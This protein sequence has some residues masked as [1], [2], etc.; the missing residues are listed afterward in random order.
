VTAPWRARPEVGSRLALRLGYRFAVRCGRTSA[1]LLLYPVTA[2]FLLRRAPERRASRAFLARVL[3][4]RAGLR[5]VARHLRCFGC[6][7]LDRMFLAS[8]RFRRFDI[9]AI[10][11]AD[12][13]AALARGRGVLLFGSHLGSLDA[14]RVLSH[15]RPE[16]PI[17]VVLD[18]AQGPAF[19]AML[20]ELN[21]AMAATVIP[22]RGGGPAV[23]L[24]I[25]EALSRNAVVALPVDRAKPGNQ[26]V[27]ARFLGDAASFPAAP[28][29][30]AATLGVPI[31]LAFGLYRGANRYD[32]HFESFAEVARTDRGERRALLASWVQRYAER[33]EHYVRL[34]PYNWFNFYDFWQDVPHD[35]AARAPDAAPGDGLVRRL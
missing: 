12:L 14:L 1:R 10:G 15:E 28:W 21:P 11:L 23:A 9:R 16:V 22:A 5:E 4:R 13:D 7:I 26:L 30:L 27:R 29:L 3:G 34:A 2:Y 8:E 6:T 24:A 25:Q 35:H 19:S 31:V 20:E 17:R 33:L 32:L 18:V